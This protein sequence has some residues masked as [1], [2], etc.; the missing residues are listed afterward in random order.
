[1]DKYYKK[2]YILVAIVFLVTG[3]CPVYGYTDYNSEIKKINEQIESKKN[4]IE[5]IKNKQKEYS[6]RIVDLNL[7]QSS[8]SNEMAILDN[9]IA[10]AEIDI[11]SVKID[12]NRTSLELQRT[13]VQ[14]KEKESE[15]SDKKNRLEEIVKIISRNDNISQLETILLNNSLSEFLNQAKYLEDV[16]FELKESLES[17]KANKIELELHMANLN[18][19]NEEL[20][21]LKKDLDQKKLALDSEK[22]SKSSLL[23][24]TNQSEN[25]FQRLLSQAKQEQMMAAADISGL[26]KEARSKM[27]K[28][29]ESKLQFNDKGMNWPVP[30]NYIS[31]YFHDPDYPFRYVFEHPAIDIRAGQGTPIKAAASGYVAR[32]KDSGMGYNYIMLVHG[33]GLS[34][35]YGH[36]SKFNCKEDELVMQGQIIGYSGGMPGTPGAGRLTTGPHL[37]F[38]VRLN[39]IPVDPLEYLP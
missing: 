12:I 26:E 21:K 18:K 9:R 22:Q 8:L 17:L 25:K 39:G 19:Q 37:H 38:E 33:N 31:A 30:K 14:I 27:A 20:D 7:Q 23:E 10:K 32:A 3:L 1:M 11:E 28:M 35:V 5:S 24:E 29:D 4:S 15:I 2:L 6:N 36:V 16:N 13:D 34:T